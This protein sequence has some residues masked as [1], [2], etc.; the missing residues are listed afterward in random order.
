MTPERHL[1]QYEI[2]SLLGAG[3]MGEVY[4]ALDTRLG[5]KAALKVLPPHIAANKDLMDRFVREAQTASRLN[6]P[7]IATI[8]DIG[9]ADG[10]RFIA[11]EYIEGTT[12]AV[13]ISRRQ[14]DLAGA[15]DVSI[16][17]AD[18]LTAAHSQGITHRD[19]KPD[20]IMIRPDG[21]VK[22]LD[23]GLAKLTEP[24]LLSDSDNAPTMLSTTAT[25]AGLVFGTVRYMSPEQARGE[26]LDDRTDIFSFG[27]VLYEMFTGV[28]PFLG[29]TASDLIA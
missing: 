7:N 21:R 9:E 11:M 8:Y 2:L 10:I 5:R 4:L 19:V 1:G 23:F 20:N 14:L 16:Q 26:S 18:A 28:A 25:Q 22:V 29:G 24:N 15:L 12:L 6:H 27:I 13:K 3:G 17:I